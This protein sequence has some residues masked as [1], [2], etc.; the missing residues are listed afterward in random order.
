MNDN[1]HEVYIQLV[2]A[3]MPEG[4][5]GEQQGRWL[6]KYLADRRSCIETLRA[7]LEEANYWRLR[8]HN[9]AEAMEKQTREQF[10][11]IT[12]LN[13]ELRMLTADLRNERVESKR[14]RDEIEQLRALAV[15][16]WNSFRSTLPYPECEYGLRDED[17]ER[18]VEM[19]KLADADKGVDGVDRPRDVLERIELRRANRP[20][21]AYDRILRDVA[22]EIERLR[23]EL[24][25]LASDLRNERVD[26]KRLTD[27]ITELRRNNAQL[28]EDNQVLS[29]AEEGEGYHVWHGDL[30]EDADPRLIVLIRAAQ[31]RE[32]LDDASADQGLLN[33]LR[34]AHQ[35]LHVRWGDG[36]NEFVLNLVKEIERLRSELDALRNGNAYDCIHCGEASPDVDHWRSCDKH[37]ARAEVERL[38]ETILHLEQKLNRLKGQIRY[39][40]E[41]A[42]RRNTL[43]EAN[44]YVVRC[45]GCWEGRPPE[46]ELLSEEKVQAVEKIATRLRVWWE[47]NRGK[48]ENEHKAST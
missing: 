7:K 9:D 40:Q 39:M 48:V 16:A 19:A 5:D 23:S 27:E 12:R 29:E 42:E 47:N 25:M 22:N 33:D 43:L 3:G 24:R 41:A 11:E 20:T 4:L 38:H 1:Q 14:L 10:A 37:P 32:M 2:S 45:T 30:P 46:A 31:L 18:L 26:S 35:R 21:R 44:G 17:M 13:S 36:S 15:R 28:T 6:W 8:G 34:A